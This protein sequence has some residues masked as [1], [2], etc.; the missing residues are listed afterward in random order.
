MS[1]EFTPFFEEQPN[2]FSS[3][4]YSQQNREPVAEAAN[5][6]D[7]MVQDEAHQLEALR[8]AARQQGYAE[9]LKK[10]SE[11][12]EQQKQEMMRWLQWVQH[13]V[14][15][16]DEQCTDQI[17]KTISWICEACIAVELS[18]HPEQI[19]KLLEQIKEEL[20]IVSGQRSLMMNPEDVAWLKK[21][22]AKSDR[23]GFL[24]MLIE[25]EQLQRGDFY[26]KS[27]QA[28]LDGRL[29]T[30]IRQIL[31]NVASTDNE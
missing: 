6:E 23:D 25:D 14:Q 9:G 18:M 3:S 11:E 16:V 5:E 29:E 19:L 27:E 30:R 20:P 12:L 28:E 22:L 21:Q 7:D 1:D 4:D 2:Q 10:A 8:E 17:V 26:F 13:P 24:D 31:A 15:L